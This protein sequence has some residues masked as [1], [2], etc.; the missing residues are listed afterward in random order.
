MGGL[1]TAGIGVGGDTVSVARRRK[2]GQVMPPL[3][4][5]LYFIQNLSK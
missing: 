2:R 1:K 5:E 4:W 3:A